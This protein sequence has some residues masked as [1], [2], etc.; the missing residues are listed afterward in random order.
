M[1]R[2][3]TAGMRTITATAH[4]DATRETVFALLEDATSWKD[5]TRFPVARYEREGDPPPHGV[6]AIRNFGFR[7]GGSREEVVA[8]EPPYHLAYTLLSGV[9]VRDYRADVHLTPDDPGTRITW[10][11]TFTPKYPGTGWILTPFLRLILRDFARRLARH[12]ARPSAA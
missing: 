12:A 2:A 3:P 9:P 8:H 1:S 11:A 7:A 6:G 5:W 10:T 4:A